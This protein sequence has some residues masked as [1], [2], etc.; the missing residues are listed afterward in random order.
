MAG[1]E[2]FDQWPFGAIFHLTAANCHAKVDPGGRQ[3]ELEELIE[4][5]SAQFELLFREA[6]L[7]GVEGAGDLNEEQM[8]IVRQEMIKVICQSAIAALQ[9]M[10]DEG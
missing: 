2:R 9:R 3:M 4:G 5:L 8:A 7:A 1:S 10:K 6:L